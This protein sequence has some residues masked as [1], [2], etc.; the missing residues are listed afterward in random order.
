MFDIQ[1]TRFL[2][3][4]L[5]MKKRNRHTLSTILRDISVPPP[6]ST[7]VYKRFQKTYICKTQ[8]MLSTDFTNIL[9]INDK[10]TI[11]DICRVH[12]HRTHI[13]LMMRYSCYV[14]ISATSWIIQF[15]PSK[16]R[17]VYTC[18][19]PILIGKMSEVK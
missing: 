11:I 13:I 16:P 7:W 14:L 10:K 9:I 5:K 6:N 3:C 17:G 12:V 2:V 8:Y 15:T 18:I 19:R 4:I 1:H